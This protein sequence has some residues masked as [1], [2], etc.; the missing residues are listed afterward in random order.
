MKVRIYLIEKLT[1]WAR[2]YSQIKLKM[3]RSLNFHVSKGCFVILIPPGV[4][5]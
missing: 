2:F 3:R 4:E 1:R 5:V